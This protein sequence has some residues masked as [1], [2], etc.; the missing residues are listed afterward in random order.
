VFDSTNGSL[1]A[2]KVVTPP[3]PIVDGFSAPT[4]LDLVPLALDPGLVLL[5]DSYPT[6]GQLDGVSLD[7]GDDIVAAAGDTSLESEVVSPSWMQLV[8]R[9]PLFAAS[10]GHAI[11]AAG[12][13]VRLWA[14]DAQDT[15]VTNFADLAPGSGTL[16]ATST[17]SL[18]ARVPVAPVGFVLPWSDRVLF[19]TGSGTTQGQTASSVVVWRLPS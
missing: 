12:G 11:V 6:Y 15:A 8:T 17:V 10:S 7:A 5:F 3:G 2:S 4:Y 13:S 14:E 19:V 9:G 1:L 18:L 16:A